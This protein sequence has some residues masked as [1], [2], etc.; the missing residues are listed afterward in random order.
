MKSGVIL[1]FALDTKRQESFEVMADQY[2]V[3]RDGKVL[4]RNLTEDEYFEVMENLSIEYYQTG[5]PHP[6]KIETRIIG[7][8]QWQNQK[9]D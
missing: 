2:T 5:S 4:Y 3:L 8:Y 7:D 9:S 6:S 1:A